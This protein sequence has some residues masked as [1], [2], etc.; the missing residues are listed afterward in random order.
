M[1]VLAVKYDRKW[2]LAVLAHQPEGLELFSR[3]VPAF[4]AFVKRHGR[5][6][7]SPEEENDACKSHKNNG[8]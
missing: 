2:M 6:K 7:K 4:S 1:P 5:G 8:A 3:M